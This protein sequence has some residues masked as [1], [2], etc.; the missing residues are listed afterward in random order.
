MPSLGGRPTGK[1]SS[2]FNHD[3]LTQPKRLF[4][5]SSSSSSFSSS[6]FSSSPSFFFLIYSLCVC[7]GLYLRSDNFWDS[8]LSTM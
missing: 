7:H 8:V 2:A 4:S 6:S 5:S 1:F 3:H